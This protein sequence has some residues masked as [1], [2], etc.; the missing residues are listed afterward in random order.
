MK[1]KLKGRVKSAIRF[2][3]N[4]EV[5]GDGAVLVFTNYKTEGRN[6]GGA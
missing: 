5:Y 6:F 4:L 1:E 3:K 2:L